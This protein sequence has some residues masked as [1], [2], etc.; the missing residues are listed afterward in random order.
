MN[1]STNMPDIVPAMH[2]V[3][4]LSNLFFALLLFLPGGIFA[5]G[6]FAPPGAEWC[7]RGYD[8]DEETLG[9]LLVRYERDTVVRGTPTK[10][11][12]ILAKN[13]GPS[14]LRETFYSPAELFQQSGDSV[15]YYVPAITD[16]V[17]LF[18]ESYVVGEETTTWMYNEPFDVYSV[19]ETM[20][21]DVP[22][23]VAKMNLLEW[24]G[25]D[26]PV[27][28]YGALGPDRGFTETWSYFLE[29]EGGLNLQAFRATETPEIKV[30]ARNQCFALME[31]VDDRVP[32]RSPDEACTIIPFPNPVATID[33][34]VQIRFDCGA[35]RSGNFLLRVYNAK[36]QEVT[37]P[38]R[39][40][41]I[42]TDFPVNNLPNGQYFA[43]ISGEGERFT[44]SFSKNR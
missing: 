12:S 30:V 38:R 41:Y 21:D 18:K 43:V 28:M 32:V 22:I 4:Q 2:Y 34:W 1:N 29:G 15:F 8:G 3:K 13:L 9:Y 20:V 40:G 44:F 6:Q 19:E 31:K 17:Y 39:L 7:Y 16:Q 23:S 5:Q 27:T 36:G 26:L 14:G 42:P 37:S 35:Y 11:F 10:V 25:R 24:L 33:E